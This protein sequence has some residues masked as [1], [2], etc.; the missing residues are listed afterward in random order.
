VSSNDAERKGRGV[1]LQ[2]FGKG[3]SAAA[4][5]IIGREANNALTEGS[6]RESATV[7]WSN[8]QGMDET[9]SREGR[10]KG[11]SSNLGEYVDCV[12]KGTK[13]RRSNYT[14]A[15]GSALL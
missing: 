7:L 6:S 9:S 15:R 13:Q 2:E 1:R 10:K 14:S 5:L 4:W 3:N 11:G 8:S 12:W